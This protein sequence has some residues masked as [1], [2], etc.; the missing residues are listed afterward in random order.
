MNNAGAGLESRRPAVCHLTDEDVWDTTMRINAKSR[1]LGCK[2]ATAHAMSRY[3]LTLMTA[4]TIDGNGQ[5]V[6]MCWA[7]VPKESYSHWAW[8]LQ[9]IRECSSPEHFEIDR[10]EK[11][12]IMSNREKGPVRRVQ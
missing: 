6:P 11:L 2:Y 1:F 8:F 12:V 9:H 3:R 4:A 7:L 10:L 5:I